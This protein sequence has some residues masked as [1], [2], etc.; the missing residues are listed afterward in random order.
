MMCKFNLVFFGEILFSCAIR[1]PHIIEGLRPDRGFR[2]TAP[3]L[4]ISHHDRLLF[5]ASSESLK[6]VLSFRCAAD[7]VVTV[8]ASSLLHGLMDIDAIMGESPDVH[9]ERIF[10]ELVEFA[11]LTV[12]DADQKGRILSGVNDKWVPLREATVGDLIDLSGLQRY[13]EPMDVS[14]PFTAMTA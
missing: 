11:V 3:K 9:G 8:S 1:Y 12:R 13:T 2:M 7:P 5:S 4:L 14:D 10:V 6:G